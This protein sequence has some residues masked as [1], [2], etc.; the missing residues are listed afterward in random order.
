MDVE[1]G[2]GGPERPVFDD[3][4]LVRPLGRG[5]MG[6]VWLGHDVA[7]DRPVA[8]KFLRD[9]AGDPRTRARLLAEARALARIQHANV[10]AVFRIG[11][12]DGRPYVASEFVDGVTLAELAP[13]S[14][15]WRAALGVAAGLARGLAAAHRQGVLHC[16]LKPANVVLS[17]SG[18]AKL[19]DFGIARARD[20]QGE[21]LVGT[22]LYMAPELW[23]GAP[24]SEA[25]DLYALG[26]VIHELLAGA[27]APALAGD[28]LLVHLAARELP[29]LGARVP[30]IPAG[31]ADLVARML[32]RDPA[33]RVRSAVEV[34]DALEVLRALYRGSVDGEAGDAQARLAAHLSGLGERRGELG[35]HFY[36]G[37]FAAHPE[38]RALFPADM[39]AQQRKLEEALELVVQRL[40]ASETLEPLLEGLGRRHA[41]YGARAEHFEAVG[42]QLLV[43]LAALSGPAWD[44]ELRR[45]WAH[46][47]DRIARVMVRGL[48]RVHTQEAPTQEVVPPTEW[49]LP[50]GPPEVRYA[51]SG[52]VSV[53]YQVIGGGPLHLAVVPDFA[54]QLEVGWEQPAVAG[55]LRR[56]SS[57][58]T[59]V[60][61]DRRGTGLSDRALDDLSLDAEIGDLDA[62]LDAVGVDRAALLGLGAGAAVASAYAA[63]RPDR[64]RAL[65]LWGAAVDGAAP[66]DP[67]AAQAAWGEPLFIERMAPSRADDPA[68][69]AWWA[70]SLRAGAS[71]GA[72]R[73]VLRRLAAL[74]LRPVLAA[75]RV[76]TLLLH[77][78]G[79][80]VAPIA[81]ARAAAAAIDGARLRALDGDDH[82]AFVGDVEAVVG[83][84]QAF[85]ATLPDP[86]A[87]AVRPRTTLALAV[88]DPAADAAARRLFAATLDAAA[89]VD[90][91]ALTAVLG[92]ASTAAARSL[93]A[94]ARRRELPVSVA[95][96]TLADPGDARAQLEATAALARAA[97][98][99][100]LVLGPLTREL[101]RG[102]ATD[103][104]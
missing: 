30:G 104:E 85:L 46:A 29:H 16:D 35:R 66:G 81:G 5:G 12:V 93:H 14:L 38:L 83:E 50:G 42:R 86:R 33:A 61:F 73:A 65:A 15:P 28:E 88:H 51:R 62:V 71:P 45:T 92:P 2:A 13:G 53:A 11:E 80:R 7:L 74:D 6:T 60:L 57:F 100:E 69:R 32:E 77:R 96:L 41:G 102:A 4:R 90:A 97:A 18:E 52:A 99:G 49:D 37:L 59:V 10:A 1:L 34:V 40:D 76:P 9:R 55:L 67:D 72:A 63:M 3:F 20:G 95:A 98:P 17:R 103:A 58:A 82:L 70:R 39:T 23:Q 22:P 79:D 64:A 47:Y 56:L 54:A 89:T 31:F 19:I 48:E 43:T 24:H 84:V 21:G 68:F 87:H 44:D 91:E 8:L 26:L 25:T 36:A 75:I 101:G 94:A 27:S 78:A